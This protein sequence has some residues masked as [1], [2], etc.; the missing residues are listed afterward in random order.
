MI[1]PSNVTEVIEKSN[2]LVLKSKSLVKL[3]EYKLSL[4]ESIIGLIDDA[5]KSLDYHT[6]FTLGDM[7]KVGKVARAIYYKG[8]CIMTELGLKSDIP[9]FD[10][11]E[12]PKDIVEEVKNANGLMAKSK[13]LMTESQD[14]LSD[15]DSAFNRFFVASK[16]VN[17]YD[18]LFDLASLVKNE[19]VSQLMYSEGYKAEDNEGVK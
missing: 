10:K 17:N 11:Q 2:E 15:K 1:A 16:Q 12:I 18:N 5:E 7:I 4:S 19:R 13:E 6:M 14:M 8:F 9:V 3:A